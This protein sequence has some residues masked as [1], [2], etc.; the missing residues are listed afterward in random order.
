M[1]LKGLRGGPEGGGAVSL[2]SQNS[3]FVIFYAERYGICVYRGFWGIFGK[4]GAKV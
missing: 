1:R 3:E 4:V 2:E